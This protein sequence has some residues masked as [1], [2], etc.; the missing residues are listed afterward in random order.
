MGSVEV[1]STQPAQIPVRAQASG[2]PLIVTIPE[3]KGG[4]TY[5]ALDV[6]SQLANIH[7]G[8]F[9]LLANLLAY[10]YIHE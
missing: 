5:V 10:P 7:P 9:R 1:R 8:A 3:Q 2:D 6:Y 4:I